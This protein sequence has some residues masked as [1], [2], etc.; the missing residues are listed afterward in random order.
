M[1]ALISPRVIFSLLVGF[2][3][4]GIVARQLLGGPFVIAAAVGGALA[5]ELGVVS[6]MWRFM[7]RFASNPALTLESAITDEVHA[8]T[9]FDERGQGLISVEVDGQVAQVLATLRVEDRS[10]GIHVR[11][12]DKLRVESVD[13]AR[14]QCTVSY[15]STNRQ[16]T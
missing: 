8:V 4:T 1:Y 12:G 13:A 7:M 14:N 16:L 6:P 3:A 5:F 2:G 15:I 10:S 9:T 11:A